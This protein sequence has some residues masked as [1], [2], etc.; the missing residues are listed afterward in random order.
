MN[1]TAATSGTSSGTSSPSD[2]NNAD[3]QKD[4][5]APAIAGA[6][7]GGV[8]LLIL[9][10]ICIYCVY[11][12]RSSGDEETVDQN[13]EY[14]DDTYN[15]E[16]SVVQQNTEYGDQQY[17]EGDTNTNTNTRVEQTGGWCGCLPC[18]GSRAVLEENQLYGE[19][20]D[21]EQYDQDNYDTRVVDSNYRYD[22][23]MYDEEDYE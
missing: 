11:R 7:A 5:K 16:T 8:C 19:Q 6:S 13:P 18:G 14:G 21:Y 10:S 15:V 1:T 20:R 3:A 4:D 12:R 2:S 23:D 22:G 17:Y 9:I